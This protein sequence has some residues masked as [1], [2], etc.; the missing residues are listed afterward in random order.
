VK[1]ELISLFEKLDVKNRTQAGRCGRPIGVV[2]PSRQL[3]G[4]EALSAFFPA[5]PGSILAL[6]S[7]TSLDSGASS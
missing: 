2:D 5:P 3:R 7:V 6:L 4:F 1:K